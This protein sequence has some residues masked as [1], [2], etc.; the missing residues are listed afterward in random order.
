[1]A[2][3]F[4]TTGQDK[5]VLGKIRKELSRFSHGIHVKLS[6]NVFGIKAVTALANECGSQHVHKNALKHEQEISP[7]CTQSRREA[8]GS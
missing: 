7:C 2:H 4:N 6:G 8:E 5:R 1:M 3:L